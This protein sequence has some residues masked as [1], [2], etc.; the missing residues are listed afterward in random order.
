MI[1]PGEFIKVVDSY[2]EADYW[3]GGI[4]IM[5]TDEDIELLKSGKIINFTVNSEY[6]CT[7]AYLN[8]EEENN[9]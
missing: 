2:D 4:D 9:G 5:I 6:G 3:Y 1:V 7:I 8:E